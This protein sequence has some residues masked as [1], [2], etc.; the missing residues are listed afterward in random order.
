MTAAST[1]SSSGWRDPHARPPAG[2]RAAGAGVDRAPV[3]S[4]GSALLT[5][6]LPPPGS[7]DSDRDQVRAAGTPAVQVA[8]AGGSAARSVD[9]CRGTAR[10]GVGAAAGASPF[11]RPSTRDAALNG[12]A[13]GDL[14][15]GL[16][17]RDASAPASASAGDQPLWGN[18]GGLPPAAAGRGGM[19]SAA[20]REWGRACRR[21]ALHSRAC[22][23]VVAASPMGAGDS[24]VGGRRRV[25]DAAGRVAL[26][27]T[28][29]SRPARPTV[30]SLTRRRRPATMPAS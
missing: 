12:D 8:A 5:V 6:K 18:R 9:G 3:S 20:E 30:L 17:G 22:A 2:E 19:A 21:R 7:I 25:F 1:S 27:R 24:K 28:P 11:P 26:T 16:G 29:T 13:S 10:G 23:P 4:T 14:G 15:S